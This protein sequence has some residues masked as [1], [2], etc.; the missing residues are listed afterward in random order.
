MAE[1]SQHVDSSSPA[2]W[3]GSTIQKIFPCSK[4]VIVPNLVASRMSVGSAFT[5]PR[6]QGTHNLIHS[7]PVD[8]ENCSQVCPRFLC[9]FAY[10][11]TQRKPNLYSAVESNCEY[12]LC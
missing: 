10:K 12:L 8:P 11:V 5:P 2:P 1:E 6:A 3:E 7:Y 4:W 9:Y